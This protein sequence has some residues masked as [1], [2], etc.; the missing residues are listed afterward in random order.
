MFLLLFMLSCTSSPE[1]AKEIRENIEWLDV[2]ITHNNDQDL[3]K[4]LLIGNSIVMSYY[5]KVEE[6]LKGKA[7]V[8]RLATSKSIGDSALLDEIALVL[9]SSHFDVIHFNNGLHGWGYSEDEYQKAFPL[10]LQV[11]KDNAPR[12]KL[13]W[14]STTPVRMGEN[15]QEFDPKV[16]R[17]I[18]RNHI[19][20]EIIQRED[21]IFN[22]LFSFVKNHPEY[23]AGGDGTHLV[24]KGVDAVSQEVTK[25][26]LSTL[27]NRF[28]MNTNQKSKKPQTPKGAF[29]EKVERIK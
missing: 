15:M 7:Y 13:I 19:A 22:D 16:E 27:N 1:K 17:I 24:P 12:A 20:K 2:W 28:S 18:Q 23:Y 3:P 21:I 29:Q 26:L 5:G 9:K 8:S 10:F 25:V 14:A 6:Q 11:I 4:V